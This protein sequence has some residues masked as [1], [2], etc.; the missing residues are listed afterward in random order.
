MVAD[1]K[2]WNENNGGNEG[3]NAGKQSDKEEWR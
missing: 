1:I 3:R 2:E